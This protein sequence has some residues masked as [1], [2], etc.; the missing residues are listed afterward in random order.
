MSISELKKLSPRELNK[1]MSNITAKEIKEMLNNENIKILDCDRD[2]LIDILLNLIYDNDNSN[3]IGRL[4]LSELIKNIIKANKSLKEYIYN[5]LENRPY[6]SKKDIY[7]LIESSERISLRGIFIKMNNDNNHCKIYST[8][9]TLNK[10]IKDCIIPITE[11]Y[12]IKSEVR[13]NVKNYTKNIIKKRYDLISVLNCMK[14]VFRNYEK[15]YI[16]IEEEIEYILNTL[17]ERK[18][19]ALY[20]KQVKE[21]RKTYKN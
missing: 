21:E 20:N 1:F 5:T 10:I 9:N 13:I 18:L 2:T 11:A 6:N 3:M 16:Y 4:R 12:N 8:R 14:R 17:L 15:D 19:T 7:K